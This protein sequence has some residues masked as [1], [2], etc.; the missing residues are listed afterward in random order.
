MF[1]VFA[2]AVRANN[3]STYLTN[4]NICFQFDSRGVKW[5]LARW[6]KMHHHGKTRNQLWVRSTVLVPRWKLIFKTVHVPGRYFLAGVHFPTSKKWRHLGPL[7]AIRPLFRFS[8]IPVRCKQIFWLFT[9]VKMRYFARHMIHVTIHRFILKRK[10][11]FL[12]DTIKYSYFHRILEHELFPKVSVQSN[13]ISITD[14]FDE[15]AKMSRQ[16]EID[17]W[18][19]EW[20]LMNL[21][22]APTMFQINMQPI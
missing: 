22:K 1:G 12:D 17:A 18:M 15:N 2:M 4:N 20:L 6:E 8:V 16:K 5:R 14:S 10:G 3:A 21:A 9:A 19:Y 13:W 7:C 11:I